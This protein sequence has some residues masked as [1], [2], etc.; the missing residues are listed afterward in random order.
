M[1][2]SMQKSLPLLTTAFIILFVLTGLGNGSMYKMI[3][4]VYQARA[5][6]TGTESLGALAC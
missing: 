2:A 3:L 5:S 6:G 4:G 1:I